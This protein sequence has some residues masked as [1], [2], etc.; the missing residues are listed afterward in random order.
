MRN[1]R[2]HWRAGFHT[3]DDPAIWERAQ[4]EPAVIVSKDEDF[5][6]H[7]ILSAAP[8]QL[9]WISK[10]QLFKYGVAR[11]ARTTLA[12]RCETIGAGRKVHR[13][14]RVMRYLRVR[15]S[16]LSSRVGD[17]RWLS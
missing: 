2:P 1:S 6:D 15:V 17:S 8:V 7:W 9:V 10:R 16:P 5:V 13:V 14:T 3:A 4:N 12:R 11:V